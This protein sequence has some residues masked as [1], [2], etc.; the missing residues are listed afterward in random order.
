MGAREWK[1]NFPS[2]KSALIVV[3]RVY[4]RSEELQKD[5][6]VNFFIHSSKEKHEGLIFLEAYF[7]RD[8]RKKRH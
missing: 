7:K 2:V 6:E 5:L 4:L 3:Q 8:Q 1:F